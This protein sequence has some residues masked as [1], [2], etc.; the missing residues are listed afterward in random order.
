MTTDTLDRGKDKPLD[1]P[2]EREPSRA[3]IAIAVDRKDLLK[4]L[5]AILPA[6]EKRNT[7]PV[8]GCVLF[9]CETGC[10]RV[11]ATN[12]D[13]WLTASLVVA[14][15]RPVRFALCEPHGLAALLKLL[16]QDRITLTHGPSSGIDIVTLTAGATEAEFNTLAWEDFPL[17]TRQ[18]SS[19]IE[20]H[21]SGPAL[22]QAIDRVSY[23]ISTEETR[24]YLN[25]IYLH[26]RANHDATA[27][28]PWMAATNG[29]ML[30]LARI[31]PELDID[32][33]HPYAV[34]QLCGDHPARDG[35]HA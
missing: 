6:N 26:S 35:S 5:A 31:A 30:A 17:W 13:Q 33:P 1:L 8:L 15:E 2:P 22:I 7:I 4:A 25:G 11:T 16:D 14:A 34:R 21:F 20:L 28:E 23:A 32:A 29:H 10:L 19:P 12:M 18:G 27:I 24:Y 9:E 3:S